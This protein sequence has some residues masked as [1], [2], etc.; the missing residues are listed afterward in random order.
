MQFYKYHALGNDMLVLDPATFT[1]QLTS[2]RIRLLCHRHYGLGADGICY[3]PL[4]GQQIPTMRFFNPDGSEAEKS[5]NGL[6]IFARYL[7][8]QGYTDQHLYQIKIGDQISQVLLQD[9]V[10]QLISLTM[11]HLSFQSTVIPLSGPAR[12][13]VDEVLEIAGRKYQVTAVNVGNP[14]CVIFGHE[15]SAAAARAYGPLIETATQF[16]QRINV[17]F[18]QPLDEHTLQIEIWERGAGYTLASGTSSC[19]AAGA[20]IRTGR[21]VS[22]VTVKMAGGE[23]IVSI[24]AKG[25][26]TLTGEVTAVAEGTL[27]QQLQAQIKT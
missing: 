4:P 16:P 11:G 13:V 20:A 19:A 3:G 7:W 21:C 17:Q 9:A 14:H 1:A 5:G 18:A 26:V 25:E 12:E 27:A 2:E 6:R 24:D 15:V 23:V 8:D 10:G 22:P